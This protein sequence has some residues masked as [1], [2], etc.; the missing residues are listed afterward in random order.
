M[1][2]PF[3]NLVLVGFASTGKTAVGRV[4]SKRL[5]FE[6]IDLDDRVEILH[7]AERGVKRRCRE[8]YSMLGRQCF[9]DYETQ[10]LNSLTDTRKAVIALGGGTPM[11]EANRD[12]ARDL[13]CVVY[14]DASPEAIFERMKIK[15]FP[16]YLGDNPSLSTLSTLTSERGPV[17]ERMADIVINNTALSAEGAANAIVTSVIVRGLLPETLFPSTKDIA[18]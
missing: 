5:G 1:R 11:H 2:G 13:G 9:I 6:F 10:A 7:V 4:L 8:I 3:H 14:L 12:K 16:L 18:S 15:G 17:Y